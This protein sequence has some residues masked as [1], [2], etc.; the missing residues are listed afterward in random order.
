MR[1]GPARALDTRKQR[2][3]DAEPP[4]FPPTRRRPPPGAT[5]SKSP[6]LLQHHQLRGDDTSK[7][8]QALP[9]PALHPPQ[10]TAQHPGDLADAAHRRRGRLMHAHGSC[11]TKYRR[12]AGRAVSAVGAGLRHRAGEPPPIRPPPPLILGPS[13]HFFPHSHNHNTHTKYK[14]YLATHNRERHTSTQNRTSNKQNSSNNGRRSRVGERRRSRGRIQGLFQRLRA[15]RCPHR[16]LVGFA[17]W[18]GQ[19]HVDLAAFLRGGGARGAKGEKGRSWS[20]VEG[21]EVEGPGKGRK[22]SRPRPCR[23]PFAPAR[24]TKASA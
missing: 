21:R 22:A 19:R 20:R 16:R 24:P 8:A 1:Y 9:A 4:P 13:P 18:H 7:L 5:A 17:V 2:E 15:A 11:A 6:P 3:T 12:R 23:P 14:R 10:S